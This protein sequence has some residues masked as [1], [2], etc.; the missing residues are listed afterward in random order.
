MIFSLI[1]I[2]VTDD[3]SLVKC[4]FTGS[5]NNYSEALVLLILLPSELERRLG[6][7]RKEGFELESLAEIYFVPP[8]SGS[9]SILSSSVYFEIVQIN[10]YYPKN[11]TYQG[12]FPSNQFDH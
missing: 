1:P 2:I 5:D 12:T 7:G 4:S 3:R 9:S 8:Y 10:S 11:E 6:R